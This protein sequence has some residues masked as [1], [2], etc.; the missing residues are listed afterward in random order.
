ML[1]E[2]LPHYETNI[3]HSNFSY[4]SQR[5][6]MLKKEWRGQRQYIDNIRT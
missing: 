6:F 2:A 1:A 3:D 4:S 5:Y